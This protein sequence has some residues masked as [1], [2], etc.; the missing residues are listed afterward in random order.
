M[1]QDLLEVLNALYRVEEGNLHRNEYNRWTTP[2]TVAAELPQKHPHRG[3]VAWV[4]LRLETLWAGRRVMQLP[5]TDAGESELRDVELLGLDRFEGENGRLRLESNDVRGTDSAPHAQVAFFSPNAQVAY[6]SRVAE[7]GR[8]LALN[9]QRFHMVPSTGVL[10]YERRPQ[11]RP[12]RQLRI[13]DLIAEWRTDIEN[14]VV[15]VSTMEATVEYPLRQGVQLPQLV[16]AV[17][18]TLQ[19]LAAQ[20]PPGHDRI[21]RFQAGSIMATLAGLYS[22]KYRQSYDAHVVTAGVGSGKSYAFQIGALIH[23]AY[24]LLIGQRGIRVVLI[25]PR[26]VLAANQFQ[27]LEAMVNS[28]ATSLNIPLRQPRLDAGGQL[29]KQFLDETGG[30]PEAPGILYRAIQ[31]AYGSGDYSIL[32]SNLDT[33]DN[34]VSHPESMRHL[35]QNLDLVV[36]DEIHLLNGLYGSHARMLLKRLRLLRA[37]W[38][39]R[40]ANSAVP[41]ADLLAQRAKVPA[42][43]IIGASATIAEP[44]Q[45]VGRL[46]E[47]PAN[48][49]MILR[50]SDPEETGWVHHFFLRQKPEVSTMTALVNATACLVHNRRNGLFREYYQRS[51]ENGAPAPIALDDLP[52]AIQGP[53]AP[54]VVPRNPRGMHKTIGFC[55]SLDGVGRWADL[56]RDNEQTKASGTTAALPQSYPYFSRF[57]EP[58]WRVVHQRSFA[59]RPENWQTT[60]RVHY[61]SLCRNCKKGIRCSTERI[62]QGLSAVGRQRLN[63]L[64]DFTSVTNDSYMGRLGIGPEFYNAPWF[65]PL[66]AAA[67]ADRIENLDGCAFFQS[68]LCW[69]WSMDHAGNNAP[70]AVAPATPLNGVKMAWQRNDA[71][72]H[73]VSGLRLLTFS[74]RNSPELLALE[75]INHIYQSSPQEALQDYHYP[76]D[77]HENAALLIG[78]PR[79]EVGVDLS[80]VMD[81]ITYRAMRNPSSLQ[82]KVGRVGREAKS[83]SVL[84]HLVTMSTRDQYYFRN[85]QIALD[86]DYLQALPLHEDNRIVARHHF[87]IAIFD[88]LGLQGE[89]PGARALGDGGHRLT[90]INDFGLGGFPQWPAKIAAVYEY[91][92]GAHPHSA[93]NRANL[94]AFLVA[95]GAQPSD[96]SNPAAR[97]ALTPTMAPRSQEVG[98]IDVFEHEFGPNFFRTPLETTSGH[99]VTLAQLTATQYEPPPLQNPAALPRHEAFVRELASAENPYLRR[100]YLRNV[101]TWPL[102]RRGLPASNVPGD[103]P[104]VWP[105]NYFESVG[106]ETVSIVQPEGAGF[107]QLSF[108]GVPTALALLAPGTVTYRFGDRPMKVIVSRHHADGAPTIGAPGVQRVLLRVDQAEFFEPAPG[109]AH[110]TADDLPEGFLGAAPVPVFTPRQIVVEPARSQPLVYRADGMLADGDSRPVP[111]AGQAAIVQEVMAPPQCYA[112]QWFRIEFD[113]PAP[114]VPRFQARLAEY[115]SG[116]PVPAFPLPPVLAVFSQIRFDQRIGVTEFVWGLDRQFMSRNV[117]AA[118]LVYRSRQGD[119]SVP[120]ALGHRFCAPAL[121]FTIDAS[122]ESQLRQLLDEVWAHPASAAYQSLLA[123]MFVAFLEQHAQ[124]PVDPAAPWLGGAPPSVFAIRN[125]KSVVFFHLLR[126]WHPDG[127]APSRPPGPPVFTLEDL[128]N[129]FRPDHPNYLTP[130][131]FNEVCQLVAQIHEPPSVPQHATTL[132]DTRAYFDIASAAIQNLNADF[133]RAH[134]LD[135]L[136]NSLGLSL[137]DAALRLSGAEEGNLNYFYKLRNGA[138]NLFLFD[139][140]ADGNGT[141]EL[142]RNHLFIP[143]AERA[144][145]E[146]LRMLGH[147]VD[148]LPTRDFART[149]EETLQECSS[150]HAAHL[151]FHSQDPIVSD[152]WRFLRGEYRGERER[153]GRLYDFVRTTLGLT[154][155]DQLGVLRENPEFLAWL[156]SGYG[157]P[158]VGSPDYPVYQALESAAGFCFG[159]CVGCIVS[160]ETNLH[161]SL[162]AANTVNKPLLDA[163]YRRSVCEGGGT[164]CD[165]CYPGNGPSRTVVWGRQ[166]RA[167]AASLGAAAGEFTMELDLPTGNGAEETVSLVTPSVTEGGDALVMRTGLGPVGV[168]EPR[169]R[170]RMDF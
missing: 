11:L 105:P 152:A 3:D 131:L 125:L 122:P 74:S 128:A 138:A 143:N 164:L 59:Q 30:N 64:W 13:S 41:F 91:L 158:L 99:T 57:Q 159:G 104:F 90:L 65:G 86:P 76:K 148:P 95:L 113:A 84:V 8:L 106:T 48:H 16:R 20:L 50:I 133:F 36:C 96:I 156:S 163:F 62:P 142:I 119:A 146:R 162:N 75:S 55:D 135:L 168:P 116:R 109:C 81:G 144:L 136:L 102:F 46:I 167:A 6:R 98:A 127:G 149:L 32:I 53:Y 118:R 145:V 126:R 117:D 166:S 5:P 92:F 141:V 111:A 101:L 93:D 134:A 103:H 33:L 121:I 17:E 100:S 78:S 97:A 69:W 150:S 107:R 49:V 15:R 27:D 10:R 9:Y 153:A 123:Q 77:R 112:L 169:V 12:Q 80:N 29:V 170:V 73:F 34:R 157:V 45:H 155:F 108:E 19:A 4:R 114:V 2:D 21:A 38:R 67:Q 24:S 137:H 7:L 54:Q 154:S 68:G 39:L 151:A 43:Y 70:A 26:V 14:G 1:T 165:V 63:A 25:Y 147:S 22:D 28:V 40:S 85:P 120:V 110:L 160:P 42:M 58:L 52:N 35:V 31:W 140:D 88:F 51:G 71:Q 124:M 37:L 132:G 66:H 56:V 47:S 23:A 161:G 82:Q 115:S 139:T 83:D 89:E 79:L 61:G 129:C 87:F 60:L 94:E 44:A 72:H 130:A 18:A